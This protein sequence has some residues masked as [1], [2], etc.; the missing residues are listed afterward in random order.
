[1]K[2]SWAG[3][4]APKLGCAY[5][6]QLQKFSNFGLSTIAQL[7]NSCQKDICVTQLLSL[8]ERIAFFSFNHH[9]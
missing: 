8:D 1:M 3:Q 2:N 4:R 6:C 7:L 9:N 5:R